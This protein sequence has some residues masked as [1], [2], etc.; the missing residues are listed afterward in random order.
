MSALSDRRTHW[1]VVGICFAVVMTAT[2]IAVYSEPGSTSAS[3]STPSTAS[4]STDSSSN[5]LSPGAHA[6][7]FGIAYGNTLLGAPAKTV[8]TAMD[9]A[10]SLGAK[11]VRVDLPWYVVQPTATGPYYWHDFDQLAAA[12]KA[13]HLYIDAILDQPPAWARASSCATDYQ[14]PPADV[15]KYAKFAAAAATRYGPMGFN[16]WEI[17]NEP[18]IAAWAPKPDPTAYNR[19]LLAA[20]KAI[21]KVQPDAFIILGGLA[22]VPTDP[23][24]QYMS[25]YD[26]LIQVGRLGGTHYVNAVGF[27]P[28]SLPTMPSNATNF[29]N[30]S[31][32][33]YNLVA[34]LS[35]YGAPNVPIWL[36][37]TGGDV[38]SAA[39]DPTAAQ[40]KTQ[41]DEN[42]QAAYATDLIKTI[43]ANNHVS[44]DFWYAD[45]DD[46]RYKLFFGLRRSNDS[47]RPVFAALKSAIAGCGCNPGN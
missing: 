29:A 23:A 16:T 27:H 3:A 37:E 2:T 38:P 10:V 13:H 9:D 46:P 21:R 22:A 19:L 5:P 17:W 8:N 20:A 40:P 31:S 15:N 4:P 36:T 11:W 1:Y 32:T 26:F 25:A 44:A 6:I 47:F 42:T 35:M 41:K 7:H 39:T 33:P 30:I 12:A 24:R 43:A 45:H 14:C 18:N 34:A 28:Y